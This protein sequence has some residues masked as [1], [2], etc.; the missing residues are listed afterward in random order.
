MKKINY[1]KL[2]RKKIEK[3]T[4]CQ[5]GSLTKHYDAIIV[6]QLLMLSSV[7]SAVVLYTP[8]RLVSRKNFFF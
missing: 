7:Y 2:M 3:M 4:S 8:M 6:N 1:T 5:P